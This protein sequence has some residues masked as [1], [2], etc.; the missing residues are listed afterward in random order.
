TLTHGPIP[1]IKWG[2]MTM[3]FKA[4]PP[5]ALP[6][7]LEPGDSVNF[8]F[9]MDADGLPQLTRIS[10]DATPATATPVAPAAPG[11]KK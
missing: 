9:Y 11:S 8:E 5:N 3:D 4:P 6:R 2:A 7:R 10:P 1:S